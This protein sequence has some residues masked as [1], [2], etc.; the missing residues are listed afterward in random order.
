MKR[1][2]L[3]IYTT[4]YNKVYSTPEAYNKAFMNWRQAKARIGRLNSQDSATFGVNKFSDMSPEEFKQIYRP[5]IVDPRVL[6]KSCLATGV[7][8]T[9]PSNSGVP[10]SF[11][12]RDKGMVTR[13][14]DQGQCGSC[15]AFSTIGNME[16]LWAIKG[17]KIQEFSEQLVV[18]CSHGCSNEPPYGNVCNQGCGGGWQWNAYIDIEAWGGV[19][20]EDE[21]PYTAQTQNCNLNKKLVMAPIRNYTCLS[22]KDGGASEADMAA[23]LVQNGP[24]A[25]ALDATPLQDYSSGVLNP[26]PDGCMTT[27]LDHAVL[28]VGYGVDSSSTPFWIVK[29]SWG[30]DWG[31][32]GYF[33][34]IR[35][36]GAC[37][38]N[39]AVSS[40]L[41]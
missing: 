13:V 3:K 30:Q 34:L 8:A 41:F 40:V 10:T 6:A 4:Q 36:Q 11:D 29:N 24:L 38:I 15:W 19:E 14:K 28:I 23:Y 12:W 31:E 5:Q 27:Q 35:G 16:S 21:Y 20:T 33:R 32:S 25:V 9:I 37:G 39:N 26:G 22:A 7:T 18:D 2:L 17:N 1:L